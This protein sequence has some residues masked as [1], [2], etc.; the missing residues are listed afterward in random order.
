MDSHEDAVGCKRE[1]DGSKASSSRRGVTKKATPP[2]MLTAC[3]RVVSASPRS[4]GT[5][6]S[7]QRKSLESVAS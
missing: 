7:E 3:Q 4:C 1:V 2:R 6:G 5:L